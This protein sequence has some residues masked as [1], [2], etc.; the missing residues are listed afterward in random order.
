MPPSIHLSTLRMHSFV[1]QSFLS[2]LTHALTHVLRFAHTHPPTLSFCTYPSVDLLVCCHSVVHLLDYLCCDVVKALREV[3]SSCLDKDPEA[4]PTAAKLLQHRFFVKVGH[5]CV[6]SLC[7]YMP[8][9]GGATRGW[10]R[11]GH[12]AVDVGWGGVGLRPAN[13][14]CKS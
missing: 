10:G 12:L 9:Q 11:G 6:K 2:S 3:V 7:A 13:P 4:R 8:M 14:T 5:S 1:I